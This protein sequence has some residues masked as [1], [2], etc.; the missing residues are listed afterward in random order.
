MVLAPIYC[1][2]CKR[3]TSPTETISAFGDMAVGECCA[4]NAVGINSVEKKPTLVGGYESLDFGEL[5]EYF[6]FRL[7]PAPPSRN[8]A[9]GWWKKDLKNGTCWIVGNLVN[10]HYCIG[11]MEN[12]RVNLPN[13]HK[14]Y[15]MWRFNLIGSLSELKNYLALHLKVENN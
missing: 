12:D 10:Q 6:K 4:S 14:D 15:K 11:P 2:K 3:R 8:S 5:L 9:M 1:E 13:D 7:I